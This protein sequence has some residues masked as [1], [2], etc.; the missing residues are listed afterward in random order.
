MECK[1]KLDSYH[2]FAEVCVQA[3]EKL[4]LLT[5]QKNFKVLKRDTEE[6][7]GL[8]PKSSETN[9]EN[10]GDSANADLDIKPQ[11][12]HPLKLIGS[13]YC[14]PLC[15]EG[16]MTQDVDSEPDVQ[17]DGMYVPVVNCLLSVYLN[18]DS[19]VNFPLFFQASK[20]RISSS[21]PKESTAP[22]K[23]SWFSAWN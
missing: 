7:T 21:I 5:K 14:C 11:S 20:E 1:T 10:N 4:R 8:V 9:N 13:D 16:C 18:Y 19:L 2:E 6:A 15:V 23:C 12:S 22:K 3:E 17:Y